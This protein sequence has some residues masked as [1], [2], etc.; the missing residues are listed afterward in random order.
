MGLEKKG[1]FIVFEGI[2]G[3]GTSTHVHRLA[4]RIEL[5]NKY[6]DVLKT[7]EPWN[8]AEID[9][10]LKEEKDAYSNAKELSELFIDDRA[11]HVHRL[12]RPNVRADATVICSRYKMSTCAYQWVQGM[13]LHEL[14]Q[15]HEERGILRPDLTFFIDVPYEVAQARMASTRASKEKFEQSEFAN[16]L[17]NAYNALINMAQVD[18]R[19]FGKVVRVDGNREITD[20]SEE[21]FKE[22]LSVYQKK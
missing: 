12:I 1:L 22:F 10:K 21:I 4:E 14:L 7:H 8:K 15:M 9:K 11:K 20:V 3:S 17:V 2:D 6:Q 13:D 18:Q 16:K 5:Q 19:V